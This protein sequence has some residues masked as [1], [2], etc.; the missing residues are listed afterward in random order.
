MK[1]LNETQIYYSAFTDKPERNCHF[2]APGTNCTTH[3]QALTVTAYKII[4]TTVQLCQT[5][6]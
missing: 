3:R 1:E 6:C 4:H 2:P 5:P